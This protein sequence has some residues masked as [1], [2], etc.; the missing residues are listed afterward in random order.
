MILVSFHRYP[1]KEAG[2]IPLAFVVKDPQ[3]TLTEVD[4]MNFV[5][6]QVKWTL[7]S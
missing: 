6:D 5:A 1:D 2:Q 4:V 7:I 3:S